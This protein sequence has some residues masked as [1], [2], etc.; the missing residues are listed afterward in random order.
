MYKSILF[1]VDLD[2]ES[3]WE[4]ALPVA[5]ALAGLDGAKIHLLTVV[6][7]LEGM[8]VAAYFPPDFEQKARHAAGERLDAFARDR[9]KSIAFE[10]H[11]RAGTIYDE[12]LTAADEIGADLIV[13][14]SHRPE[15]ADY[16]IGPNADRVVRHAKISVHVVRG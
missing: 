15:L 6:P 9:M 14:A 10:T 8:H 4:K 3:S 5:L 2:Q 16:L 7:D 13:M 1:P 11:V 12:I